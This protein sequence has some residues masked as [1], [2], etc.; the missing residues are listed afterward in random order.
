[1]CMSENLE[2]AFIAGLV[3]LVVAA[4]SA[5]V[6]SLTN[7]KV[8]RHAQYESKRTGITEQR[9]TWIAEIR[10]IFAELIAFDLTPI[11]TEQNK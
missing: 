9:M 6:T 4:I 7:K 1:M 5:M 8:L 11:I 3:A 10:N 2:T